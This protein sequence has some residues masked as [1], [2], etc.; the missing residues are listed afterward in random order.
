MPVTSAMDVQGEHSC[1]SEATT[2]GFKGAVS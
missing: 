2:A 1:R